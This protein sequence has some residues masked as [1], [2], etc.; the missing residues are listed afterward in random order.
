MNVAIFPQWWHQGSSITVKR[1]PV[2]GRLRKAVLQFVVLLLLSVPLAAQTLSFGIKAG[3][4]V[5]DPFVLS[6]PPSSLNNYTFTTQRYTVGPTFELGLPHKLAFE[7]DALYKQLHYVSNPF[8]FNTFQATTTANSWEYPLLLKSY[9]LSGIIRPY[10]DLGV[11]LR[12]VGGSTAFSNSAF[13]VTQDPLEQVHSW[14]TGY[15]A[16]GGVDFVYGAIHI[17]PEIRYTRWATENFSSSNGVLGSNLN[18]LD[19]LIGVTF[20]RE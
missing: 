20:T 16:G 12:H 1:S 18:A 3:A 11:S 19:I 2:F 4:P 14:S 7:A 15:V 9:F 17:L 13:R 6:N 5:T 10:G 8:G